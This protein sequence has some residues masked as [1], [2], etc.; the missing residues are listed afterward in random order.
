MSRRWGIPP[1]ITMIV[2]YTPMLPGLMLYRGM[3][4]SLNEQMI[5][6]FTNMAMALAISGALAAAWHAADSL[7]WIHVAA[8]G[9][10]KL[11]F[12]E[13]RASDV[14]ADHVQ[15]A[16]GLKP[17]VDPARSAALVVELEILTHGGAAPVVVE[18]EEDD[19]GFTPMAF[20]MALDEPLAPA[21][22]PAA[23]W[24]VVF[25]PH[26]KMYGSANETSL[27]LR[28]LARL[29]R[30]TVSLD[31][32]DVPMLDVLAVEEGC[33]TWTVELHAPV[34]EAAV[35]EVFDYPVFVAAPKTVGITS[36]GDTEVK[37][38]NAEALAA[39][40]KAL[41]ALVTC[42]HGA[43]RTA[44]ITFPWWSRGGI[45]RIARA[46]TKVG[47]ERK[48]GNAPFWQHSPASLLDLAVIDAGR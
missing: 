9:V 5:T 40:L 46:A 11:L 20:D 42:P 48:W 12:D 44:S 34:A 14:L 27:L 22:E 1:L 29:G 31:E 6:G 35:R 21:N 47:V 30:T 37:P 33:L 4:A 7:R 16:Q 28:E 3:Y 38:R 45:P 13:L 23:G 24:R 8:A 2:G 36:T 17:P 10:D 41:G 32:T 43:V 25:K 19:F 26:G 18:E 15:A 39:R